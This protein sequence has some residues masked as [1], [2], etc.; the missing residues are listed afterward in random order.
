MWVIC[1][2]SNKVSKDIRGIIEGHL[3]NHENCQRVH[4]IASKYN[5]GV[6]VLYFWNSRRVVVEESCIARLPQFQLHFVEAEQ[7]GDLATQN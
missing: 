6:I 3:R 7:N 4:G 2:S 1:S 5:C